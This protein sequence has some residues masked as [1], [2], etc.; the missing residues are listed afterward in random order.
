M[1]QEVS[2]IGTDENA[3]RTGK[4]EEKNTKDTTNSKVKLI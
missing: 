3:V 2:R 4:E 1:S